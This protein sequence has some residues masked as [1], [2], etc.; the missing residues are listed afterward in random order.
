MQ[1]QSDQQLSQVAQLQAKVVQLQVQLAAALAAAGTA[2][3]TLHAAQQDTGAAADAKHK[4]LRDHTMQAAVAASSSSSKGLPDNLLLGGLDGRG[5]PAPAQDCGI[6]S[7]A[8]MEP[9]QGRA[10]AAVDDM[11][12]ATNEAASAACGTLAAAPTP[13]VCPL[14]SS[15]SP[16]EH[17]MSLAAVKRLS[18]LSTASQTAQGAPS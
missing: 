14:C 13:F 7:A 16:D 5:G 17:S 4:A 8:D 18:W 11:G 9:V 15:S 10:I 3:P 1:N 2:N 12:T 6:I